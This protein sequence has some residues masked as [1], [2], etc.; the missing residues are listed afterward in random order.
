MPSVRHLNTLCPANEPSDD[1]HMSHQHS[2]NA[3]GGE[4]GV[5]NEPGFGVQ[6]VE[7]FAE[8]EIRESTQE[9]IDMDAEAQF[10]AAR[11]AQY[12]REDASEA[13]LIEQV[14]PHPHFSF[15]P[16]SCIRGAGRKIPDTSTEP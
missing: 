1:G 8:D 16:F 9:E 5:Y 7:P 6:T 10:A 15:L 14:R 4:N 3:E 12:A 13:Q 11:N 2:Q